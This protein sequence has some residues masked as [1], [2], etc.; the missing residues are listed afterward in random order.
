MLYNKAEIL[1]EEYGS[2]FAYLRP[3]VTSI[4]GVVATFM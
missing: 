2:N 4:S 3:L 1:V